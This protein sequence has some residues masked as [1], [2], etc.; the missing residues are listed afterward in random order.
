MSQS[1]HKAKTYSRYTID[2]EKGIQAYHYKK[3]S[4]H[5]GRGQEKNGTKAFGRGQAILTAA[6]R[7]DESQNTLH[8]TPNSAPP[9]PQGSM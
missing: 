6:E 8:P 3:S 2:T 1:N 9:W 7:E 4:Y 5:N